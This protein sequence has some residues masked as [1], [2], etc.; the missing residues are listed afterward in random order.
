MFC[1]A[2]EAGETGPDTASA[3]LLFCTAFEAGKT[4][5]DTVSAKLLCLEWLSKPARLVKIQRVLNLLHLMERKKKNFIFCSL[6]LLS[7]LGL[8]FFLQCLFH[9]HYRTV[10]TTSAA[11]V[12]STC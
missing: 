9:K 4:G 10:S 7:P 6:F 2:F 12:L 5:Q 1:T 3:K 8:F 11:R